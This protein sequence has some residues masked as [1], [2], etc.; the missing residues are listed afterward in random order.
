MKKLTDQNAFFRVPQIL[1]ADPKFKT[2]PA[3]AKLM[4]GIL[5]DRESLSQA[6]GWFDN[7]GRVFIYYS[8][9]EMAETLGYGRDKTMN[10]FKKLEEKKL[11]ERS[12]KVINKPR[13]ITLSDVGKYDFRKS[14]IT[15]SES[16][17]N[18]LPLVGNSDSNNTEINNTE[19]SY[20]YSS[21]ESLVSEVKE[22][23]DYK[24]FI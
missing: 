14:E 24:V 8:V 12:R 17:K 10:L 20:T 21:Y 16:G 13:C 19:L 2:L 22:Q 4:Y 6:N 3:E 7:N 1:F 23:K 11:I 18:R 9:E 5:L 15:F